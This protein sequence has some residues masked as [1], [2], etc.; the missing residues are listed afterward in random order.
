MP[1]LN[2]KIGEE[3]APLTEPKGIVATP[4][5]E[6]GVTVKKEET[7]ATPEKGKE[8][9]RP[10]W[11][12]EKFK[13]AE[14]FA[15]SY[16]ELEKKL[17]E[18]SATPVPTLP[19]GI[20][21]AAISKEFAEN[22]GKLTDETLKSLEGKGVTKATLDSF[23][24]GQQ[25]IAREQRGSLA[26]AVGGDKNLEAILSWAK[27]GLTAAERSAY[28]SMIDSQNT[29]GAKLLLGSI[30][31]KYAA[32]NGTDPS[33]VKGVA[34][35]TQSGVKPFESSAQLVEAIRDKRYQNDPA[36]RKNVEN[37]LAVSKA[38]TTTN[39]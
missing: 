21:V 1:E 5:T 16:G 18:K 30:A 37:R 34:V 10:A 2:M 19:A 26:E 8:P 36:Y 28:N 13:T 11:L 24:A 25:A 39:N 15:K 3:P 14:D 38:F 4:T 35:A 31:T 23:V 32:A 33:L 29:E 27:T 20:D 6:G 9:D 22:G 17:G 12:P 7:P